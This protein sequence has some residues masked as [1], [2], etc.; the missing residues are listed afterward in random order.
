[1]ELGTES[2]MLS[3]FAGAAGENRRGGGFSV[4]TLSRCGGE[5]EEEL[6][7]AIAWNDY[8]LC[9]A[10]RHFRSLEQVLHCLNVG[11]GHP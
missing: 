3:H 10:D 4:R 1:M 11:A 7:T 6:G 2:A 8:T 9:D 5:Y